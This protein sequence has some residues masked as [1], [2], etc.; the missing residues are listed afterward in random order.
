MPQPPSILLLPAGGPDSSANFRSS[1]ETPLDDGRL[2]DWMAL[3]AAS[4]VRERITNYLAAWGLR[5][6]TRDLPGAGVQP[7]IW[8]RIVEGTLALFSSRDEYFCQAQ[9]IGLTL[10]FRI[11]SKQ[12]F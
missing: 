11:L 5:D 1:V 8:D 12:L 7:M 6:N 9:V 4:E 2:E 10:R 3:P